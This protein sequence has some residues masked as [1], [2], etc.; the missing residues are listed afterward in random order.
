MTV[1]IRRS[2]N[3]SQEQFSFLLFIKNTLDW[4]SKLKVKQLKLLNRTSENTA[5]YKAVHF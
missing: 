3:N 5:T 4:E 2:N 1:K